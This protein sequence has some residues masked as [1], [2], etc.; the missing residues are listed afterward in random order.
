MSDELTTL[1][2]VLAAADVELI[3]VGGLAAVAQGAPV[4][5]FDLDV[6]HHRT[7]ANVDRLLDVLTDLD[8]FHRGREADGLRPTKEALL[9]PGHQL[10]STRLGPLDVLGVI[11]AGLDYEALLPETIEV[12]VAGHRVRVLDL[13][14][15]VRIK[16]RSDRPKD[17][18]V[19]PVLRATL[20]RRDEPDP[21]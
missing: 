7:D 1:L 16:E 18:L 17:R 15:M 9:G 12:D 13:A 20:K 5:T 19:L 4:T 10:L 21:D 2:E 8:A 3:V 14:A 11:E 6:V